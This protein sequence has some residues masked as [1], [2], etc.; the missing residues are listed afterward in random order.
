M[1]ATVQ[2]HSKA[3]FFF[4]QSAMARG[5]IWGLLGGLAATLLMDILL[6][7]ILIAAG[8][9]AST[10]FS[11]VGDT[12]ATLFTPGIA[13]TPGSIPLGIAAHYLIGPLMGAVFGI[14]AAKMPAFG[15]ASRKKVVILAVLYAEI[16]SQP[17]LAAAAILLHMTP[18]EM[19]QW[20]GGSTV[21][22]C[23]WG[24]ILGLVWRRGQR[25]PVSAL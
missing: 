17:L 14:A 10:C 8:M 19:A 3:R 11:I 18:T 16:L 24:T 13:G 12:A 25:L 2:N 6:M 22:H 7:G 9:P 23:L 1:L 4:S 15:L 21:M 5:L 20:F